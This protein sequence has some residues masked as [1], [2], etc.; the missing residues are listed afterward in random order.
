MSD[1][2]VSL[3]VSGK[4][5]VIGAF[6]D[7]SKAGEAMGKALMDHTKKLA[8]MFL[9]FEAVKKGAEQFFKALEEGGR[10]A[11][12]GEQ[13]GIA[14]EKLVLLERAFQN[15]GLQAEDVGAMINRMQKAI[16]EG[17]EAGSQAAQ[18]LHQLGLEVSTLKAMTPDH[19]FE[20]FGK[21]IQSIQDPAERSRVAMEIFGKS[22]GRMLALF[23]NMS[24]EIQS[25]KEEVGSYASVMGDKAQEFDK[26]GDKLQNAIGHK[27][28]EFFAGA[29]SNLSGGLSG[30]AESVAKF[31]AAALGQK[32]TKGLSEPMMALAT[33]LTTG[34]FKEALELAY[35][36]VK[37][38]AMKM[39][40]ELYKGL[41]AAF[42]IIGT[43]ASETFSVSG[44]IWS[45]LMKGL[46]EAGNAIVKTLRAAFLEAGSA[47]NSWVNL[48]LSAM[49]MDLPGVLAGLIQLKEIHN[50]FAPVA[51]QVSKSW[52]Q[53]AEESFDAGKSIYSASKGLFDTNAQMDK[54]AELS[55]KVA[56]HWQ[57]T[58]DAANNFM[59]RLENPTGFSNLDKQTSSIPMPWDTAKKSWGNNGFGPIDDGSA[60]APAAKTPGGSLPSGAGGPTGP[61]YDLLTPNDWWQINNLYKLGGG[62]TGAG[63][64]LTGN[65]LQTRAQEAAIE[66]MSYYSHRDDLMKSG[67]RESYSDA[68]S[69]LAKQLAKDAN[70]PGK[71][72]K[73]YEQQA[74]QMLEEQTNKRKGGDPETQKGQGPKGEK[75][76]DPGT[77]ALEQ[78]LKV[79][80]D[81]NNNKLPVM[82]LS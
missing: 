35:E 67:G 38:Q 36:M 21:A 66:D 73:D 74:K 65:L 8:A 78:I 18:K 14:V 2:S 72:S 9:G 64:T 58:D 75:P 70:E 26:L 29:L 13:T 32:I 57:L 45:S 27:V 68:V 40:N 11:D 30:L 20:A 23:A 22:G 79:I 52:S 6:A 46:G 48:A 17:G 25:A 7:V 63:S 31:D 12:L 54:L 55:A 28:I 62:Q 4:D 80:Q 53:I 41:S 3:G 15:N 76:K 47:A 82:A 61:N 19:Q 49:K 5:T 24:E 43:F 60:T 33:A 34:Q 51:D 42:V 16:V 71:L 69:S 56:T 37:L 10:L 39:G 81:I 50:Q 59:S 1:V 77:N 44:P